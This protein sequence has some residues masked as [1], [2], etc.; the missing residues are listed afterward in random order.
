MKRFLWIGG[1]FLVSSV[2]MAVD[3]GADF[4]ENASQPCPVDDVDESGAG[5][6][7]DADSYF[8]TSEV[9]HE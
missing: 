2:L 7:T 8:E 3:C 4:C 6:W 9:A 5:L 1:L